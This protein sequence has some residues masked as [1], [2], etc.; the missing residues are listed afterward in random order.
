MCLIMY[1]K[2]KKNIKKKWFQNSLQSNNDGV[3]F[4]YVKNKRLVIKKFI[5][6]ELIEFSKLM[7]ELQNNTPIAIHQRF[8]TSG[9]KTILNVHPFQ[10][11]NKD[12]GDSIDLAV[13]HNGI[14]NIQNIEN[15]SDTATFVEYCIKP[16]LKKDNNLWRKHEFKLLL[17]MAIGND[18]LLFMDNN[19]N[20]EII[21]ENRGEWEEN[22]WLSS[23]Y[24]IEDKY[25]RVK[26]ITYGEDY[27]KYYKYLNQNNATEKTCYYCGNIFKMNID[28]EYTEYGPLC[29]NCIEELY[30]SN[31]NTHKSNK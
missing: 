14:L 30:Y 25:S 27:S 26:N 4:M 3:G 8:G 12:E 18:K 10:I 1:S 17:D 22:V 9:I 6:N 16:L 13:M 5:T 23:P 24:Y 7:K 2:N 28:G 21:G 20:I 31:S 19:N 29:D 15:Y 11:L